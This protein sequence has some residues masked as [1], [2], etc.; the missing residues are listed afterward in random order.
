MYLSPSF[1][2]RYDVYLL[3]SKSPDSARWYN[4]L[5]SLST[6]LNAKLN[7]GSGMT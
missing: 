1:F 4:G 3:N 6:L 5:S 7:L 2:L